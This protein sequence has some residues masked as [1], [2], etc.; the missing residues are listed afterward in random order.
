MSVTMGNFAVPLDAVVSQGALAVQT[1][2][3]KAIDYQVL[4]GDSGSILNATAA[5]VFTLPA[6][7]AG[8]VFEFINLA[9]SAMTIASTEGDNIVW[10]NDAAADSLA[11]STTSHMIGGH[12]LF[13]ANAAGTL[14]Y[15][16]NYSPQPCTVTV[17]T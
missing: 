16:S 2:V 10:D 13:Q 9:N 17:A 11:F 15:V 3:T 4:V 8:L 6:I 14:W 1:E 5:V 7:A 12:L